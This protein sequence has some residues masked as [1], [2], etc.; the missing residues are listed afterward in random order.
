MIVQSIDVLWLVAATGCVSVY[1]NI[2]NAGKRYQ[3][4]FSQV[5]QLLTSPCATYQVQFVPFFCVAVPDLL[6]SI[7]LFVHSSY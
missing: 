4:P 6:V 3:I 2:Q 1:L 7:C 5:F